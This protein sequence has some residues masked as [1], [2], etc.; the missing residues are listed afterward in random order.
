MHTFR[1]DRSVEDV[2]LSKFYGYTKWHHFHRYF[3]LGAGQEHYKLLASLS[4]QCDTGATIYDIGTHVGFSALAM[5]YNDNVKV[6][7][8]DLTDHFWKKDA[9]TAKDVPNVDIQFRNCLEDIDEIA[10]SPL[11][12]LD[13]D[14]HDGI[15]EREILSALEAAGFRGIL[16]CDD[17]H[18]NKEMAEWWASVDHKKYDVTRF[19]HWSGTGII[20]FDE[21]EYSVQVDE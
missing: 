8:Y 11:V 19:G 18:Q 7:S 17:I 2:D 6:V 14:P 13:V 1:V 10:K 5:A 9:L 3:V 15:Q 20:V 21:S 4:A 16:V 12:F